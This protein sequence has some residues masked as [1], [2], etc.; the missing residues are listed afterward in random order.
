ML[1]SNNLP[2]KS[3]QND[4][5]QVFKLEQIKEQIANKVLIWILE[6]FKL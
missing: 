3:K 2:H 5:T 4:Q 1:I 6:Y